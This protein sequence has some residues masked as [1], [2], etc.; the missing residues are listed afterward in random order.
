MPARLSGKSRKVPVA[1]TVAPA[2]PPIEQAID[3]EQPLAQP[4]RRVH[5]VG[6]QPG[7]AHRS[8]LHLE[9][10]VA[11]G[12]ADR[13]DIADEQRG[14]CGKPVDV[15]R[16]AFQRQ[17][18]GGLGALRLAALGMAA[19]CRIAEPEFEIVEA[20]PFPAEVDVGAK[21]CRRQAAD[22]VVDILRQPGREAGRLADR[23]AAASR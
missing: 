7:G 12:E 20:L 6:G 22:R 3:L 18:D 14:E 2:S 15:E 10:E 9:V 13:P 8:G 4:E 11:V 5:R 17:R 23:Q 19:E 21:A 1:L 16:A